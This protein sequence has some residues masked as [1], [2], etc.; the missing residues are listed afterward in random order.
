MW[1]FRHYVLRKDLLRRYRIE[2]TVVVRCEYCVLMLYRMHLH[3]TWSI[4]N[5]G[6][7]QL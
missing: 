4:P 3:L 6:K 2:L 5:H 7:K 1:Q